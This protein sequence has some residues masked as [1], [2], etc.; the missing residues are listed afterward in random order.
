MFFFFFCFIIVFFPFELYQFLSS[1]S[2]MYLFLFLVFFLFVFFLFSL[3]LFRDRFLYIFYFSSDFASVTPI[4]NN[5]QRA[6][7]LKTQS[8]SLSPRRS[9]N[10]KKA[11]SLHEC[12]LE[13]LCYSSYGV[14]TA[15]AYTT[16][17]YDNMR[18]L[19]AL[20]HSALK[21]GAVGTQCASANNVRKRLRGVVRQFD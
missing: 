15:A 19:G 13:W 3:S 8:Q 1:C 16:T 7:G 2:C 12:A 14:A 18:Q 17:V 21:K 11:S 10:R 4:G 5:I 20:K 6:W 9:E